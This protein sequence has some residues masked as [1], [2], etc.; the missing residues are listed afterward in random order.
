MPDNFTKEYGNLNPA[1]KKAVDAIEGPVMVIAGPGTGKTQILTVR[2]ANILATTDTSPDT[3]LA[4]TFTESAAANMR[5]RLV[6]LIG[7][8]GYYAAIST[9]HGFCNGLIRE[10]P[11]EFPGIIS[12]AAATEVERVAIVRDILDAETFRHLKPFGD[13][14]YFVTEII[15]AI[16][17]VKNEGY[18]PPALKALLAAA[19]KK[20]DTAGGLYH[21]KGPH[22]GK[23][24]GENLRLL[25]DIEKNEELLVIYESYKNELGARRLYDFEDMIMETVKA[26]RAR[27]D[28]LLQIQERYQYILV[29]EHQDTN[30]AQNSVLELMSG[31]HENPNL[32]VVGDEKQAIFR[33]QGASLEN[34][35]YFK[36][37]Y[38]NA[39]LVHLE[40]NYRSTQSILD[41][42]QNVIDNNHATLRTPLIARTSTDQKKVEVHSF[43][44]ADNELSF[45]ADEIGKRIKDGDEPSEI[46]VL[47]R[48]NKDAYSI[49]EELLRREIPAALESDRNILDNAEIKKLLLMF[50]FVADFGNDETLGRALHIDFLGLDPL[51]VYRIFE[52]AMA[53]RV[54]VYRV[55][56]SE[57][58]IGQAGLENPG[59]V[60]ALYEK[61]RQWKRRSESEPFL[62]F[63]ERIVRES[64]FLRHILALP[65]PVAAMEQLTL[66]YEEAKKLVGNKGDYKLSDFV[67]QV[68]ILLEHGIMIRGS[69]RKVPGH[70]RLMTAHRAKGLEFDR[71]FIIGATD[72]HWGN[73]RERGKFHLPFETKVK[74]G[75]IER[76][77][78][79]RRLFYMALTRARRE[80]FVS[81]STRS[82]DGREQIPSQFVGE[83]GWE[84]K[85]EHVH[86]VSKDTFMWTPRME[87][88]HES[89]RTREFLREVFLE[90][91]ISPT[92]LNNYLA[93]PW[94]YFYVNLIRIPKVLTRS[95]VFGVA[96]HSA[97]Q[98]FFDRKREFLYG[99][100]AVKDVG[101][102]FLAEQFLSD[103]EKKP[104]GKKDLKIL[105]EK[106]MR[107]LGA[108][109][110][111]YHA[112]WNY[113]TLTEYR[114]TASIPGKN[115]EDIKIVGN[116]DK[117][118]LQENG[119]QVVVVDYKM[120]QP[121]SRSWIEG[122]TA[123]SAR[124]GSGSHP[125]DYKRQLV[126]YKL[127]LDLHPLKKYAFK[128][129]VIDFVEPSDR[130]IFKK[131][132]FE[133]SGD[134][135]KELQDLIR[136]VAS[137][138]YDLSFWDERCEYNDCEFCGL[139][140][141]M[142]RDERPF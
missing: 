68:R 81:Y 115:A 56:S 130:G 119:E 52:Y 26:L 13:P 103:L 109:Y 114:I 61:L 102:Q 7:S 90:R 80:I 40:D 45:V 23:M 93:C 3:I 73:R 116:L 16:R 6:N 50:A 85:E 27:E 44:T 118:E 91:G 35:L 20:F 98:Q 60:T 46:A 19:R 122:K 28:F 34:F 74:P 53:K 133:V 129:A 94:K 106:G 131:E 72:G 126:F 39:T 8:S 31:F 41:A 100:K 92:A 42:S 22:K 128:E 2:I 134:E 70:V 49:A 78:D 69:S 125:G 5:R 75:D 64:G 63:F 18:D 57:K 121:E 132:A 15:T 77:E 139:R 55:I 24:K 21:E 110:D 136:R 117:L 137:E 124:G 10:Y 142:S 25:H 48:Q 95:Q 138:I 59:L 141:L 11:E 43:E 47:F 120:K 84:L 1:Q 54:S 66:F 62:A 30:G 123:R 89:S 87:A 14:Y 101:A 32:F 12:S 65:L 140:N 88:P 71:V 4:L 104:I 29:D 112:E 76:N 105:A 33:F 127:L 86:A 9:F 58:N 108:Y 107:V 38:P 113:R 99:D 97:L 67:A 82:S 96:A 37:K 36:N 135:T 17:S 51:E 83:I 79:E 111:R